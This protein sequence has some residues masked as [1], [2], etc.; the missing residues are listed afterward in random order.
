[1]DA[2]KFEREQKI[3]GIVTRQREIRDIAVQLCAGYVASGLNPN[4]K[5]SFKHASEIQKEFD[6]RVNER[7]QLME[8]GKIGR[9]HV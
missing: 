2:K 8:A 3:A 5:S 6:R 4:I 1:M 7:I 9:A